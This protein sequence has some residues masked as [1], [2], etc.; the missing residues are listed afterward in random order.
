MRCSA[1][2]LVACLAVACSF[3]APLLAA[4]PDKGGEPEKIDLFEAGTDG[5]ALYRIPGIVA[6]SKGTL[7][8]YCEARRTGKSDWDAIDILLR[9]SLDGGRT[10]DA[11]RKI[12]DA[13]GPKTKNPVALAQG[14]GGTD[15][16]TYNNPLAIVDDQGTIHL[17]YCL[18]YMRCF[19]I[20]S[21][22]EG[23]TWS[24]PREI[25]SAF[26][27][28]RP[29][30]K[31]QVLATGPGH[32]IQLTS[33]RLLVPVWLSLGTGGHAHRPSVISTI[34]SDDRGQSWHAGQIAVPNDQTTVNPSESAVVELSDGRVLLNARTESAPNRR[35]LTFSPDGISRWSK[36]KF[37]EEL[38]EPICMASMVGWTSKDK[39]RQSVLFCNPNNLEKAVGQVQPGKGRDR[40]NLSLRVSSDDGQSWSKGKTLEAGFSGYSDLAVLPDRT[41]ICFYERGSTDSKSSTKTGRLTIARIAPEWLGLEP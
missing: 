9:R 2:V 37:A 8:A 26:D 31:W 17:L 34:Y 7:L 18:E 32:G 25:T 20:Q 12:S 30:Y 29:A 15:D 5:Y 16:V 38:P 14:L 40:K 22:D 10:W 3:R 1:V 33:G 6:T 27:A 35:V 23:A 19:L 36:P 13:P 28:Y 11:P 39:S 24:E 4:D 41:I 21:R